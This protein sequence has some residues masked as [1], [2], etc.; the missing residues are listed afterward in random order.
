MLYSVL[1]T[2]FLAPTCDFQAVEFGEVQ[3]TRSEDGGH[4][5]ESW[6]SDISHLLLLIGVHT[7]LGALQRS[8]Q[9]ELRDYDISLIFT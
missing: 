2:R 9:S 4:T 8:K 7:W 1:L 5:I 3:M 6:K